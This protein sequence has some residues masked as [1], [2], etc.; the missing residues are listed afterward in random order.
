MF[1]LGARLDSA[2]WARIINWRA[3]GLY[4]LAVAVTIVAG[5]AISRVG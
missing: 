3:V 2:R 1:G 4:A 5:W